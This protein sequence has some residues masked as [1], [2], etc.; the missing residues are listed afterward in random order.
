MRLLKSIFSIFCFGK[1]YRKKE[2]KY[3]SETKKYGGLGNLITLILTASIPLLAVWGAYKLPWGELHII[4]FKIICIFVA[5][6]SIFKV[7]G[8]LFVLGIV[9]F[10]HRAKMKLQEKIETRVNKELKE[11]TGEE[12]TLNGVDIKNRECA[13]RWDLA[14]GFISIIMSILVIL[15]FITL[16][17]SFSRDILYNR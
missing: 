9:A 2:K 16:V 13:R 3:N 17:V 12:I 7:P 14:I 1:I 15:T 4:I 8:E 10:K 11:R 5:I 6:S